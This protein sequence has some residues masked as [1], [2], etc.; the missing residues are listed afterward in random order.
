M[1]TLHRPSASRLHRRD[2]WKTSAYA[3]VPWE[4]NF[5]ELCGFA[6][7]VVQGGQ[8]FGMHPHR[9]MEITTVLRRGSQRHEDTTGRQHLLG[10]GAVQTM[11]A[12][13]GI[14]HSEFNASP[15]EP[16]HSYQIWVYPRRPGGAPRYAAFHA[17]PGDQLNRF[18][19]ALSPDGREGSAV[20]GQDAFF[21]LATFEAGVRAP[22]ALHAPGN[23]VYVHCAAGEVVV[24]GQALGP[25]DAVGVWDTEACDVEALTRAELVL[26]EVP[27]ARGVRT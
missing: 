2:A 24:A 13:T 25:G 18:L 8:G 21:S 14:Q 19:L 11:S 15:T 17:Q 22:Y 20:I 3:F 23:G 1:K 6:D 4:T 27:M 5:G 10:P 7:D 12:G 9:D 26:V 16:F